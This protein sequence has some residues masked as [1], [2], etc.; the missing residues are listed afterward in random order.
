[1]KI[2]CFLQKLSHDTRKNKRFF[3]NSLLPLLP[4]EKLDPKL[5]KIAL[6]MV[7]GIFAPALDST[8]VNVAIK[9]ISAELHSSISIVQWVTTAYIYHWALRCLLPADLIIGSASKKYT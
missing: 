3:Q 6:I 5:I 9:T 4:D 7:L 8:I 2:D 1:M